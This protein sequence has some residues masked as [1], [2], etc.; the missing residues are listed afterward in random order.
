VSW[1]KRKGCGS[2][3]GGTIYV[4]TSR[5]AGDYRGG[6]R[7]SRNASPGDTGSSG[8]SQQS[9]PLHKDAGR[10]MEHTKDEYE[11]FV[12]LEPADAFS[13]RRSGNAPA[14]SE[15]YGSPNSA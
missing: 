10:H 3:V 13:A 14:D 9:T 6:S 11:R 4:F 7:F 1:E 5:V 12:D 15:V 2:A 8:R